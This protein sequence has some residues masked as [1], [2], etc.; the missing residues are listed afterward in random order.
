[1]IWKPTSLSLFH[2]K[3]FY[4]AFKVVYF[5]IKLQFEKDYELDEICQNFNFKYL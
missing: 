4:V 3:F 5:T 1:M 2:D